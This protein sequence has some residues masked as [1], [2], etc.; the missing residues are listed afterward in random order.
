MVNEGLIS[1]YYHQGCAS[2][3]PRGGQPSVKVLRGGVELHDFGLRRVRLQDFRR[4]APEI[5]AEGAVLE[6]FCDFSKKLSLK[7]AI[8]NENLGVWG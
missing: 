5:G 7:N 2:N 6:N 4:E 1:Y 8:K 3:L